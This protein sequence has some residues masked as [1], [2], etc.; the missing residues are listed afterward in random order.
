MTAR[1]WDALL[2]DL[3]GTLLDEGGRVRPR[4]REALRAAHAAGVRVMVSTGRSSEGTKPVLAELGLDAPAVV[5]NGAGLYCPRTDRLLE[6]RILSNAARRACHAFAAERGHQLVFMC[7]G[8][9][10]ATRPRDPVE[11]EALRGLEAMHFVEALDPD[12]EYVVRATF[13]SRE[14]ADSRSLAAEIEA[15]IARPVYLTHF[16]LNL[17]PEH[18]GS[19]LVAVDVH[20]PCRGK[21][22]ALRV[23][24]ELW[25]V[26]PERV[27]AVGD[28]TNDLPMMEAAGLA[29]AMEA[30]MPEVLERADRVIG[31]NDSDAIAELVEELFL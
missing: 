11:A 10:Y 7:A 13:Y 4:N 18:R 8:A 23:V 6:E 20:P 14:H 5:F 15:W 19:L 3:D 29:V 12:T 31:S 27:V 30:S 28:A 25:G 24:E 1:A 2:L 26:P 17:L 22:E 16:P 21:G 9:K